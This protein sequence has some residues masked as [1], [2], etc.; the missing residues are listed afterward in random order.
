VDGPEI[1]IADL[2]ERFV[3]AG[4]DLFDYEGTVV[5]KTADDPNYLTDNPNRRCPD[6]TKA[7]TELEYDPQISLDDGLRRSLR[8]YAPFSLTPSS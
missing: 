2:A 1:S 6:I 7:R 4:Q 3:A 8:W 5:R